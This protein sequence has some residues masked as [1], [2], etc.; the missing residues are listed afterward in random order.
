MV[1]HA[2]WWLAFSVELT[3][4][5]Q[6]YPVASGPIRLDDPD[7]LVK[8]ST[9]YQADAGIKLREGP[10]GLGIAGSSTTM[11]HRPFVALD[12]LFLEGSIGRWTIDT[13]RPSDHRRPGAATT[14]AAMGPSSLMNDEALP[15]VRDATA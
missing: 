1:D 13:W 6:D 3:P 14:K 10:C 5:L 12:A 4:G 8:R 9:W 7:N 15:P 2:R 11:T